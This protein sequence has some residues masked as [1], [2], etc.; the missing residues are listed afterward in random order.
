MRR[1]L[2]SVRGTGYVRFNIDL[3]LVESRAINSFVFFV[4]VSFLLQQ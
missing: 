1:S 4:V 2:I 3:P